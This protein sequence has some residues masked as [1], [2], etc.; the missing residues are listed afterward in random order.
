MQFEKNHQTGEKKPSFSLK[1]KL[2]VI[3]I[4]ARYLMPLFTGLI[5]LVM[6]I[7]YT[8]RGVMERRRDE[9][10]LFRMYMGVFKSTHQYLGTEGDAALDTF[11]GAM[12]VGALVGTFFFIVALFLAC[13]VAYTSCRA[14]AAGEGSEVNTR[15]K[16]LFK[17]LF[18]NRLCLFL[19]ST[20]FVIPA[21][22]P[23]YY[24]YVSSRF[25][26]VVGESAFYTML[27]RP[28]IVMVALC[29]LTLLLSL[30]IGKFER[31]KRMNMFVIQTS[32]EQEDSDEDFDE[33]F[34]E[35]PDDE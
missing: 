5:L 31:S 32:D 18:P 13:F 11:Y 26:N 4:W 27:N 22:L 24:S 33:D 17:V 34:D 20:L 21:L 6:S 14:F 12:S 35:D 28:L 19:A 16:K 3:L 29:V 25:V 10:S 8:V 9:F 7:M 30:V 1:K 15:M 2:P 23:E